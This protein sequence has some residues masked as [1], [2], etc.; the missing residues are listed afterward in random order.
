M[1]NERYEF[2]SIKFYQP[3]WPVNAT[4]YG[5]AMKGFTRGWA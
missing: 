2:I 1:T 5:K 4:A 3:S